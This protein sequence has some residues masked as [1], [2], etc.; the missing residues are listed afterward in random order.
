MDRPIGPLERPPSR[1]QQVAERI[2]R[3]ISENHLQAGDP[4]PS[5]V[6]LAQQ[7]GVSRNAVREASKSLESVG[8]VEV[9]H[10]S[11]LFVKGFS[12][13][14]L[15]DNLAYGMHEL[16]DLANLLEVRRVLEVALVER[17]IEA[18]TPAWLGDLE[19]VLGRMEAKA[20]AGQN[21]PEE[22]RDFH[23]CLFRRLDNPIISRLLDVFW[24][25]FNRLM[26]HG[27]PPKSEPLK[28]YRDHRAILEAIKAGDIEQA[29]AALRKHYSGIE[30]RLEQAGIGKK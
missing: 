29:Q 6:Q 5:E 18:A 22:D 10:G 2:R 4:L 8:I 14:P 19:A 23:L 7:L 1:P 17:A 3:Y 16:R 21:F 25:A 9:R 27:E 13:E 30:G 11:G 15:L 28:T 24:L 12:L 20:R 26:N